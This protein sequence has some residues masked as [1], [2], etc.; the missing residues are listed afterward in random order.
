MI[1][2]LGKPVVQLRYRATIASNRW[3]PVESTN[4]S[5]SNGWMQLWHGT[6]VAPQVSQ[7][8]I[9]LQKFIEC[10]FLTFL[11]IDNISLG[12]GLWKN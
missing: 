11:I 4:P 3:M 6:T 9:E 7:N 12:E 8:Y 2:I 10:P 5:A 1:L